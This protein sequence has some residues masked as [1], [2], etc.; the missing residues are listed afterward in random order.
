[1]YICIMAN[2][3]IHIFIR[4]FVKGF[5]SFEPAAVHVRFVC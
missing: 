4:R 1:M 5:I 3:S 2:V